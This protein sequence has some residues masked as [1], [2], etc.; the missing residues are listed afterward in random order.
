MFIHRN[1]ESLWLTVASVLVA[2]CL[3]A[4]TFS[5]WSNVENL[6][7]IVNSPDSDSCLF[8]TSSGLSLYFGSSRTGT[9]GMLDLYVAQRPT[10]HDPWGTP[11]SLGP[12]LNTSGYDH[13]P[14]ITPDGHTMIFT[15]DRAGGAGF[16]DLYMT[17]RRNAADDFAWEPPVRIEELSSSR[18]DYGPWGFRD[19]ST[20]RL[21][22]YF[23]SDR[24]GGPGGYDIYSTTLQ[25]DGKFS[26]P[27]V[28]P[29]LSTSVNDV[30][31][32][33]RE[34]GLE[35]FLTSNRAGG[36]GNVDMWTATRAS[37]SEPWSVPVNVGG[38]V[39]TTAGEQRAGLFSNATELHFFSARPG[40]LGGSDLYRA[41]RNRT[42]LVPIVGATRGAH[43]TE[44]RTSAQLSNPGDGEL[45]GYVVFHPAGVEASDSDPRVAYKLTPYES[46]AL[47]NIM[48]TIGVSGIGS[49]EIVPEHGAAPASV[50]RIE[51]GGSSVVMPAI[52]P[53]SVMMTGTH[54]GIKMPADTKRYRTNIA[55]RTLGTG[56]TI[57]VCMHH[58]DGTYVRGFTR[59]FAPNTLVQMPVSDLLG[60][61]V[62]AGQMVMFTVN[63]GSAVIIASTVEN[64][65][66]GLSLQVVRAVGD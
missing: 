9:L 41:T 11:K 3:S 12:T 66:S 38:P 59:Y 39:N 6:G 35:L 19:P 33:I 45:T 40:G 22:L 55:I 28:V 54:S 21:T 60:G 15:S 53:D 23:A 31:P 10:K 63:A 61:E 44:F 13:L 65:G 51:T 14:F 7:P 1:S 34:D 18:D 26:V 5:P 2:A 52:S 49:L 48:E 42:T 50:F 46:H 8:V 58:P 25:A 62:T 43:G 24:P 16:N 36:L 37:T 29:E 30:M 32:T 20:G 4:Q 57:W 17:F 56:A 27:V 64:G 47:P